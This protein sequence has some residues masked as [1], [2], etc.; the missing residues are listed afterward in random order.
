MERKQERKQQ[1]K[2][3][4][5]FSSVAGFLAACFVVGLVFLGGRL[6][7]SSAANRLLTPPTPLEQ[8]QQ[9]YAGVTITYT[10]GDKSETLTGDRIVSWLREDDTAASGVSFDQQQVKAFIKELADKYD[11]AYTVRKF[12]T[13]TGQDIEISQGDYGWRIDQEQEMTHL[14]EL[15]AAKEST[16]CE[17]VYAQTAAVHAKEDWGTTYIEASLSAQQLWL[18]KDGKCILESYFV[19]GNP[20]QGYATPKG[21]YGLTYKTRD[22]MLSGQGYDSKVKYWMPFNR[23]VGLHDAPWRKTF[24]GQIYKRSG[25][26]GCLNLPPANAAAIYKNVDKNTPVI[27]Y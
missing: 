8:A 6:S 2:Q 23:N 19:S 27:V 26:H 20:T 4:L 21:I 18:Y 9:D 5:L 22:A 7:G 16:T 12:H 13:S 10:F 3:L 15:L 25:S 11:T 17:P 24:G 1:R 14:L